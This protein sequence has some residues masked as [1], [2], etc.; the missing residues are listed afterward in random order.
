MRDFHPDHPLILSDGALCDPDA[1]AG[2]LNRNREAGLTCMHA[3]AD[4]ARHLDPRGHDP[5][6]RALVQIG[7]DADQS[8]LRNAY[9]NPAHFLDVG[10]LWLNLAMAENR[11]FLSQHNLI[12]F[13]DH[14]LLLGCCAAFGHDLL[15]DGTVNE[16]P[17]E[18]GVPRHVP[19]RLE[20]R[21]AERAE[22]ILRHAGAVAH[23]VMALRCLILVTDPNSGYDVLERA[24]RGE[25]VSDI[26]REFK[27]LSDPLL[28][29]MAAILRDADILPS[30]GLSPDDHDR[31]SEALATE[32]HLPPPGLG[33]KGAEHFLNTMLR[34]RFLS[35]AGSVYAPQLKRL[36]ALNQVRLTT[37]AFETSRLG[38]LAARRV[39]PAVNGA[40]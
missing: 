33:P 24:L 18:D 15:H 26:R 2:F 8:G 40:H 6:A 7:M 37:P 34:G 21:A 19:F 28:L 1:V 16:V 22:L 11:S 23:D 20:L 38:E 17:A 13:D 5:L 35:A 32:L 14:A 29:E 9:H 12:R 31:N 30:A 39:S 4:L 36:I 27:R 10:L 3:C 25:D